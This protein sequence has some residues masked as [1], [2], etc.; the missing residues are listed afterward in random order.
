MPPAKIL[1]IQL[2]RIGDVILT[3]PAIAALKAKFPAAELHYLVEAPG[4][5]A[6]ENNPH[7]DELHV[8]TGETLRW[9]SWIRK[10]RFDWVIDLMGNPRSALLCAFSGAA[11]KAGP[12]HVFHS[13]AYN[14]KLVESDT[15]Q[16]A[17][18]EKMRL[19]EQLGVPPGDF[20]PK[21]HLLKTRPAPGNL[22]GLNAASRKV[23]R[24][25]KPS[26]YAQL[27]R[28]LR[29]KLGC[30]ILV[31][32][33]PGEK[34]L[35]EEVARGIGP[36][37]RVT[38]ETPALRDAAALIASCR[39]FVTN[40]AGPKHL[41]VALGVPTVTVHGSS[42]PKSWNPPHP[43]HVVARRDELPCIG[44]GLNSCPTQLECMD[45]P[46]E[47]VAQACLSLAGAAEGSG[48]APRDAGRKP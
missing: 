27:G 38:P 31:F 9:L 14:R 40:C 44:C 25:W 28:L 5:E 24:R 4:A 36:G 42:D 7:I 12:A 29:D 47:K 43:R 20:L 2:R 13:W 41:A 45:L 3:T 48:S 34:D 16:Y 26:S 1:V 8:Y 10:Q 19:L 23:T 22:V 46:A 32:W 21:L 15:T 11:V 33:G 39:L 30:E 17:A 18:M 35:A 37:A 6:L